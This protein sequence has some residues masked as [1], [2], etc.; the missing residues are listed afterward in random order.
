MDGDVHIRSIGTALPGPAIDNAALGRRL[1]MGGQWEQWVETFIGTRS[2]HL[3]IDLDTAEPAHSLADLCETAGR[4]ALEGAGRA[5]EDVD[6]LVLATA[7]P[8]LLMPTTANVVADRLRING[9]PTYQIQ[10]GC[11]GAFQA[12]SL[13]QQLLAGGGYRNALVLGGDV[14]AKFYDFDLDFATLPPDQLVHYVL[15]G[16]GAGAAVLE[17]TSV[18]GAAVIRQLFT[19]LTG[20]DREPGQT[21]DWYG[22]GD[23]G[24]DRPPAIEDYKAIEERVPLMSAE[25]LDELLD[26]TGWQ[27]DEID[28]LLPPQL[29]GRMT[30][31]IVDLLA[32]PGAYEISRVREIG[33]NGNATPFFQLESAFERAIPG[34]RLLGISVES[35][36]WIKGGFAVETV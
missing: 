22:P 14:S 12:L 36:K 9:V 15:F 21:L 7:S 31:K 28:Y 35:S 23:R 6:L 1:R 29:S 27:R 34:Q 26:D 24:S 17:R 13:A 5:A 33:N 11:C 8:D 20:L 32:L 2:R 3:S 25:I 18:P 19:R 10:S 30:T 4:R 16:D